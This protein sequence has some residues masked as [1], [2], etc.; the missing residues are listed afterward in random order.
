MKKLKKNGGF[1]LV[2]MLACMVT[3]SLVCMICMTGTSISI[4]SYN[5]SQFESNSQA[6]Q[7]SLEMLMG[8]I[9]RYA[10]EVEINADNTV[11]NFTNVEYGIF[12]GTITVSD[13]G[14]VMVKRNITDSDSEVQMISD[15]V[16]A[17]NLYID[18]DGFILEYDLN[19]KLFT[20]SYQIKS[21]VVNAVKSCSFS[22]R[23]IAEN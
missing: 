13:T 6:L 19:T 14:I 23:T 7:A 1:T 17:N 20:G 4:K 12:E 10:E 16:Y 22:F 9:L 2:E 18:K 21:K 3:L 5:Q 15:A 8:D 11:N